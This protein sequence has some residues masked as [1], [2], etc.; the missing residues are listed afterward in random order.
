MAYLYIYMLMLIMMTLT[1]TLKT[2][3]RF[4]LV[5]FHFKVVKIVIRSFCTLEVVPEAAV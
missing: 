3:V 5:I 2:F 1:L 4:V